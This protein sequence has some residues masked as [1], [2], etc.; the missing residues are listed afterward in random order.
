[1]SLK[2]PDI[3]T[4]GSAV[5]GWPVAALGQDREQEASGDEPGDGVIQI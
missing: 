4:P 5:S 3:E 2:R 1:M